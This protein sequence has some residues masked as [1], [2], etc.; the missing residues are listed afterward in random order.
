MTERSLIARLPRWPLIPLAVFA[1]SRVV[2]AF[3]LLGLKSKE[4][5][6]PHFLNWP[7]I[8][9]IQVQPRTY[10]NITTNWDGQWYELI[11]KHGYPHSLSAYSNGAVVQNQWAFYPGFPMLCRPLM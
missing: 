11:A 1:L 8:V 4:T 7:G 6:D 2:D 9:P 10:A 3:I 5:T